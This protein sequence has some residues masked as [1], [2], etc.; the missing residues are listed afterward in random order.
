MVEHPRAVKMSRPVVIVMSAFLPFSSAVYAKTTPAENNVD[1]LHFDAIL[2]LTA[3]ILGTHVTLFARYWVTPTCYSLGVLWAEPHVSPVNFPTYPPTLCIHSDEQSFSIANQIA[4]GDN[5]TFSKPIG[6][7]G[8]FRN[9]L[10]VY[11]LANIRFAESE[12]IASRIYRSDVREAAQSGRQI[13]D[14]SACA[15][16][17]R[18]SREVASLSLEM[19]DGHLEALSLLDPN[20]ALLKSIEYEYTRQKGQDMLQRQNVLLPERTIML[21]YQGRGATVRIGGEEHTYKEVPGSHHTGGRKCVVEY[22]PLRV[23]YKALPLPAN[24]EVRN[25]QTNAV[26]RTVKMFNFVALKKETDEARQAATLFSQLDDN[27][28]KVRSLWGKYLEQDPN[29]VEEP[30][31]EALKRLRKHFATGDARGQ[32]VG[33]KLK[34]I[35]MLI[36][37]DWIEGNEAGLREHFS[38]YLDTLTSSGLT[39]T[40]LVGGLNIIG[41]TVEW[42]RFSLADQLLADWIDTVLATC[43]AK[44]ILDFAQANIRR[45][46]CWTVAALLGECAKSSRRWGTM[47]FDA[48]ALRCRALYDLWVMIQDAPKATSTWVRSQ[49]TWAS[50]S[51]GRTDLLMTVRRSAAEARDLY[52]E[53]DEPTQAQRVLKR[54]VDKVASE[55]N[56][57]RN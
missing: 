57:A 42:R 26:L 6:K 54:Q 4:V 45:R 32:T 12:A 39:N 50:R 23:G 10:N 35:N 24:I 14:M 52:A 8:V 46:H 31:V 30:D 21:G 48:Q 17:N 56:Q 47:R 44:S 37:L 34:R 27:E 43:H 11:T 51:T 33:H 15:T 20:E 13:L 41:S 5:T 18:T 55:A 40:T 38:Q 2:E 25:A 36:Q 22:R 28:L 9:K 16:K 19:K 3:P 1:M 53:L 7:R 49:A 29:A